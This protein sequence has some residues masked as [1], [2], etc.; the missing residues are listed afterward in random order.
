M[1]FDMYKGQVTEGIPASPNFDENFGNA[2]AS[3][4][5]TFNTGSCSITSWVIN[6]WN[7]QSYGITSYNAN[8]SGTYNVVL[9]YYDNGGADRII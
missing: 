5:A 4:T 6:K 2:A 8:L 7:D 1:N 9:E 3:N